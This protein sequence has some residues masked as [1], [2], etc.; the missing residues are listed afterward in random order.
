MWKLDPAVGRLTG[1]VPLGH[2]VGSV[3]IG[4]RT[5]WVAGNDGMLLRIDSRSGTALKRVPLG[6]FPGY[7]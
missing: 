7:V 2:V 6:V 5:V 1:A 4:E 3:A